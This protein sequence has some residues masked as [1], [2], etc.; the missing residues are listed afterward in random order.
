MVLTRRATHIWARTFSTRLPG[1]EVL[2]I[3][4]RPRPESEDGTDRAVRVLMTTTA[5]AGHFGPMIPFATAWGAAGHDI[6]VAAPASF[7]E[8]VERTGFDFRPFADAPQD[9]LDAVFSTLHQVSADE[10]NIRVVRDVFATIDATAAL[11]GVNEL[12]AEWRPGH[13]RS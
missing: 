1:A 3:E 10:G 13:R 5:G 7:R 11:P 9:E 2:E 12:I 4:N 6:A 8:A